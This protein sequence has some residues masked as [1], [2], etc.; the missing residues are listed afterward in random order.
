[1]GDTTSQ[2]PDH[3]ETNYPQS[4]RD[5]A[6]R[7]DA[8]RDL[9]RGLETGCVPPQPVAG[10]SGAGSRHHGGLPRTSGVPLTLGCNFREMEFVVS[11]AQLI[12]A[13]GMAAI[14][15]STSAPGRRCGPRRRFHRAE[16]RRAQD[17][18]GPPRHLGGVGQRAGRAR[19][20][21]GAAS[22]R[23][24]GRA[25]ERVHVR[26]AARRRRRRSSRD[27]P[28]RQR[29]GRQDRSRVA[30][31]RADVRRALRPRRESRD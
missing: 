5:G 22:W 10:C 20:A 7:G 31:R 29:D 17:R 28:V 15:Y 8:Q 23:P 9:P 13:S 19:P 4:R 12:A 25:V 18:P 21:D 6:G 3:A 26:W 2:T 24:G 27:L 14:A 1:M 16:R 30:D 11:L